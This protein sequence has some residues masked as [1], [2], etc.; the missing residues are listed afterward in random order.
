LWLASTTPPAHAASWSSFHSGAAHLRDCA[1]SVAA[2]DTSEIYA[3]GVTESAS[4]GLDFWLG[5]YAASGALGWTRTFDG[6]GN[7]HDEGIAVRPVPGGGVV[8]TAL[9]TDALGRVG[10]VTRRY[11]NS[12]GLLWSIRRDGASGQIRPFGLELAPSGGVYVVGAEDD[13]AQATNVLVVKYAMDG[14]ELWSRVYDGPA[15]RDDSPMALA[16]APGGNLHVIGTGEQTAWNPDA[17]VLTYSPTGVLLWERYYD[18]PALG[19][20][21]GLA[22][23]TDALGNLFV[24]GISQDLDG[25]ADAFVLR[26]EADGSL[27]WA[28]RWGGAANGFDGVTLLSPLS[29]GSVIAAGSSDAADGAADIWLAKLSPDGEWDWNTTFSGPALGPDEPLGLTVDGMGRPIVGGFFS[30]EPGHV[31]AL[32]ARFSS[33]GAVEKQWV[34]AGS[35]GHHD[36]FSAVAFLEGSNILATGFVDR[37]GDSLD[38]CVVRIDESNEVVSVSEGAEGVERPALRARL[39]EPGTAELLLFVEAP[40]VGQV[41]LEVFDIMGR[42]SRTLSQRYSVPRGRS[43]LEVSLVGSPPGVYL[44]RARL[45]TARG[46][47][48]LRGKWVKAR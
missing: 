30:A 31:D 3:V 44:Y 36:T 41:E 17:L 9:S 19:L 43:E 28:R 47:A 4:T 25:D 24:G 13:T 7:G 8:V 27:A 34:T 16:V 21:W 35:S 14:T 42:K 37:P 45:T 15:H 29:D 12:G 32:V 5:R 39:L 40:E 18:G 10:M 22:A 11:S 6:G 46:G 1:I 2:S 48:S 33:A 38:V 20:E 23:C 26:Y